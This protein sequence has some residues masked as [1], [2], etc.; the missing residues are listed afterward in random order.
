MDSISNISLVRRPKKDNLSE[1]T[2][3]V[4]TV[5][6]FPGLNEGYYNK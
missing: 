1:W 6:I 3:A 5:F 2:V 4:F